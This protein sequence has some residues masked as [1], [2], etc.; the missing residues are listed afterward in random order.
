MWINSQCILGCL[1][2]LSQLRCWSCLT[3]SLEAS[4]FSKNE[5]N[6]KLFSYRN[7]LKT[8]TRTGVI[9]NKDFLRDIAC[10]HQVL[11]R[12][13]SSGISRKLEILI[14]R[15]VNMSLCV[16]WSPIK[17]ERCFA[18]NFLFALLANQL[19]FG[20]CISYAIKSS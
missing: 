5:G 4:I 14:W 9:W 13:L 8:Q 15:I 3:C 17:P 1:S 6:V 12:G 19:V 2:K 18:R 10:M 20:H 11:S 16:Q 7:V